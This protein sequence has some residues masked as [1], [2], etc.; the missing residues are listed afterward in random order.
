M[1]W[2]TQSKPPAQFFEEN[3]DG[4][5]KQ[6]YLVVYNW[7]EGGPIYGVTY[8]FT[9]SDTYQY[10]LLNCHIA[11]EAINEDVFV[12]NWTGC[13][14]EHNELKLTYSSAWTCNIMGLT[15]FNQCPFKPKVE[16]PFAYFRIEKIPLPPDML[17][18]YDDF[19]DPCAD[20]E[21]YTFQ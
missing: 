20:T 14:K 6:R 21:L 10:T 7:T 13:N 4:Q 9:G 16:I 18:G 11:I 8:N 15:D 5:L 19:V 2:Q 12:A 3:F 17:D 1:V